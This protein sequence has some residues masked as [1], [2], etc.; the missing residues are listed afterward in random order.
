MIFY[1]LMINESQLDTSD[2][3]YE[4]ESIRG[5]EQQHYVKSDENV[6]M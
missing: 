5:V 1:G 2:W 6:F 4:L 3:G